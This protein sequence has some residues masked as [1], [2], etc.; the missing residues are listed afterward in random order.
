MASGTVSM[1]TRR[2][3]VD[4]M[5]T[6]DYLYDSNYIVS[7]ARDY[8]RTAFKAAM[9]SAQ[10]SLQPV[11]KTMFSEL[12]MF[13]RMQVVY[14]PN[15]RLP[16]H[17]DRS[18]AAY[19]L[20]V[21]QS[22]LLPAPQTAGKDQFKF[23]AR[24]KILLDVPS[25]TP[26]LHVPTP[27]QLTPPEP[28]QVRNRGTQSKYRETSAQTVPWQPDGQ[29]ADGCET[30]PEVLF[31]DKLEWG[32]GKP[33][34]LGD[35]PADFHTTEIINKMRHARKWMQLVEK[36]EFPRWL[37]NRNEI[38]SDVETKD[39]IFREAEID[40][41]QDIRLELLHKM[42]QQLRTKQQNRTSRKLAKLWAAKKDQMESKIDHIRRTRDRE[43]R[44]LQALHDGG[45]RVGLVQRMRAARGAGSVTQAACDPTSDLHAPLA[46][47]GYQARRRHAEIYYDPSLLALEDHKKIAEPPAWLDQCG[48]DLRKSCSGHHLPRDPMQLCERETK[49]SEQFLET[50]HNDLKKARLGA[51]SSSAGPLHVLKPR[52]L[53][54]TPRP[55]TPEVDVVQDDDEACH[56]AALTLQR[57]IR[58]RAVQTLMYEG[59]TRAAELTEELK[60]THGLQKEDKIRIAKEEARARDYH[61]VRTESDQKD[62]AIT[63]LVDEL[64]GGAVAAA[65]DFLEKELRRLKEERRQHAFI[66]IAL[67]EK[68]M[69]EAAEAGRRQKEEH[70]RREHDEMFK[71]V[72]GVTQDT[73]DAYLHDILTQGVELA[74][75]QDAVRRAR[76]AA[77]EVDKLREN[78]SMSTAEQN[79]LVAELVQQFLLPEAHKCATR[80]RIAALQQARTEVARKTIFGVIDEAEVKEIV[81]VR[82]GRP[83]D[84]TCRCLSCKVMEEPVETIHRLDPRWKFT[85]GRPHEEPKTREERYP[86]RHDIRCMLNSLVDEV[87][88][89][90]RASID[91]AH[92][93]KNEWERR[94]REI[95]EVKLDA[96]EFYEELVDR[97][98]GM[99]EPPAKVRGDYRHYMRRIRPDALERSEPYPSRPCPKELPTAI[100]DRAIAEIQRLDPSCYC[101]PDVTPGHVRLLLTEMTPK[102][103]AK[104][105]PSEVRELEELRRCK[106]DAN[107]TPATPSEV[108]EEA[109]ASFEG[110]GPSP[111]PDLNEP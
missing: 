13:P 25:V 49:W 84:E 42:Q 83:L 77:D 111:T 45:G 79:E 64:C 20:R 81:C 10:V 15:C 26:D 67:R 82:C 109:S 76:S 57:I 43:L 107:P 32:P 7:G 29:P 17:M 73:V 98:T 56:Q 96:H 86:P 55:S 69:R 39:W 30:K 62:D 28:T 50:L 110:R 66:L 74:A 100:R 106:C 87:V 51:A 85:R 80:H 48:Q 6:H 54:T 38:I 108:G 22:R 12:R 14:Y 93:I 34:R 11:Y 33:Y 21:Q 41:L 91:N 78:E 19:T 44:K 99:I 92:F 9:A 36:G 61:V 35:L 97:A 59:R 103:K 72:L 5:R 95:L 53:V 68:V 58:G 104:L 89:K 52:R 8:A 88:L 47:H 1:P 65:L 94:V 101:E 71:Q 63:A 102:E 46:R 40:E 16:E 75:E 70:R 90:S 105:L 37:K 60:T 24:P 31:L 23:T 4:T 3:G 18:Y 27:V 2:Q